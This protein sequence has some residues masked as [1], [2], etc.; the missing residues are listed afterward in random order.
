M[1]L[2][3][4]ESLLYGL[5]SGLSEFLPISTQ[6]HQQIFLHI[7]G[8]DQHDPLRDFFVALALLLSIYTACRSVI[9][10]IRRDVKQRDR[11]GRGQRYSSGRASDLKMIQNAAVPMVLAMVMLSFLYRSGG[12]LLLVWLFLFINGLIIFASGRTMQGNKNAR[13]MSVLDSIFIG[14]LGAASMLPGLSR[15]GLTTS[16]AI[17]RGADKQNA[18][19]WSLL[20]SIPA[21][22][23]LIAVNLISAFTFTGT[24]NLWGDFPFYL[25]SAVGAYIGGYLSILLMRLI[26]SNFEFSNFAFYSWGAALFTFIIYLTVV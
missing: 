3:W 22:L 9:E 13:S 23:V 16:G 25:L 8:S 17:Y 15:I 11:S 2:T 4:F 12:N 18:L 10:Q 24:I 26:V 21:L 20:I 6:A 19:N 7:A 1:N 5:V 14:I